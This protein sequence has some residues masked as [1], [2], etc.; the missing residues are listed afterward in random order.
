[1]EIKSICCLILFTLIQAQ[2]ISHQTNFDKVLTIK[3]Y[4][5]IDS[6]DN[7]KL[8]GTIT[9]PS[10]REKDIIIKQEQPLTESEIASLEKSSRNNGLYYLKAIAYKSNNEEQTKMATSFME[11]CSLIQSSLSDILMISLDY[12]GNLIGI[13]STSTNPTCGQPSTSPLT[14]DTF[15][16]TVSLV[17]TNLGPLPDTMSYIKR[18]EQE[19][20]EKIRGDKSDNRS[21]FAKYWM[22]IVPVVIFV[23][24]SNL[25]NP[26]EQGAAR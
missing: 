22:Y 20:N 10:S 19:K 25:A 12:S 2:E 9:I 26:E 13:S 23:L 8:R 16:T 5:S 7:Y 21:F 3:L 1:M 17:T 15:N 4:H 6:Y 11:T 18:M 24:I 14:L